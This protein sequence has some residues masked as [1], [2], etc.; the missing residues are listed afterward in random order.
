MDVQAEELTE[1]LK[2]ETEKADK[3][4][5]EQRRAFLRGKEFLDASVDAL[6][7]HVLLYL[8]IKPCELLLAR[9]NQHLWMSPA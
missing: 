8:H 9:R 2:E 5:I 6:S 1:W 3:V 7:V 4:A